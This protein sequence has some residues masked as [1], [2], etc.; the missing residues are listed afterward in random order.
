MARGLRPLQIHNAASAAPLHVDAQLLVSYSNQLLSAT[1]IRTISAHDRMCNTAV[2]CVFNRTAYSACP[3]HCIHH[4][5]L[6]WQ[7]QKKYP[8][9]SH[10]M[11][12]TEPQKNEGSALQRWW[13]P[14]QGPQ[15]SHCVTLN[16][17][18]LMVANTTRTSAKHTAK[19]N[20]FFSW[21]HATS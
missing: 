1:A 4:C 7:M 9:I 20:K 5:M 13:W 14:A 18:G 15:E 19:H 6:G 10:L 16:T 11:R 12:G 17:W 8:D 3:C 2:E 21:T